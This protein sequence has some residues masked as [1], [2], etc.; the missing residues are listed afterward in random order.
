M[1]DEVFDPAAEVA[2][3]RERWNKP[4]VDHAMERIVGVPTEPG[5]GRATAHVPME[6]LNRPV[7]TEPVVH[8]D[9]YDEW[10][11][12]DLKDEI[13]VR[14]EERDEDDQ[15]SKGGSTEDLKARLREDD[16]A[17]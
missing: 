16:A 7:T 1:A 6:E 17:G 13:D 15:L 9:D 5:D 10:S 8:D 4:P 12:Q 3:I 11:F 2:A 14:N